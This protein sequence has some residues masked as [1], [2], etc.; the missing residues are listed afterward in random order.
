MDKIQRNSAWARSP[1]YDGHTQPHPYA[2]RILRAVRRPQE[3]SIED[4]DLQP[5]LARFDLGCVE[6]VAGAAGR[7]PSGAQP[8]QAAEPSMRWPGD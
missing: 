2:Q 1:G 7:L 8:R 5:S 3:S 4:I 6:T